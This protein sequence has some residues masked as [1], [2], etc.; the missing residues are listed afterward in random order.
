[1][2]WDDIYVLW[3][4]NG[5]VSNCYDPLQADTP[6]TMKTLVPTLNVGAIILINTTLWQVT[7]CPSQ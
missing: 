4:K 7:D 5:W 2:Q 3:P 1:M 6:V